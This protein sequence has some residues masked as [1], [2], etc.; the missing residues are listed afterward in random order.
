MNIAK[1]YE[2]FEAQLFHAQFMVLQSK[3]AVL[4]GSI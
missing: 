3:P 1:C 2:Q 4:L